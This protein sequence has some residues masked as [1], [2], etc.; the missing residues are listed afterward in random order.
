MVCEVHRQEIRALH[1]DDHVPIAEFARGY[2]WPA[3]PVRHEFGLD[4]L[5]T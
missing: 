5:E 3:Q 4:R 1:H 2:G